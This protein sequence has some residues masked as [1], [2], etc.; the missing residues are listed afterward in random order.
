M[1][2]G[3][4]C[5]LPRSYFGRASTVPSTVERLQLWQQFLDNRP[6]Q[7]SD[8]EITELANK[9]RLSGEQIQQAIAT[10]YNLA[11]WS[12]PDNPQISLADC[13]QACRK[14]SNQQ[15]KTLARKIKPHYQWNDLVLPTEPLQQLQEICGYVKHRAIVYDRWGFDRKLAL[16]KGLSIL[17]SGSSGT[18]KTMAADI[19]AG[20]LGLELYKID[21]SAVVSKY[22]GETEK[23]LA[24]I[25]NEAETSNAILFFDEADALFGK[26]SEVKDA[27]DRYANIETSYLLQRMEE[28]AG[29]VIL[30]TNFRKNMDD[31][32]V[33]R[34]HFNDSSWVGVPFRFKPTRVSTATT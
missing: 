11:L 18:G 27:R 26:R 16:G 22:I 13:Y 10:A 24:Q 7:L 20:E 1:N 19:M 4:L 32:F 8:T 21:L 12:N 34:L 3:L 30:A 15:L 25:F 6:I 17:F 33:R 2:Y 29:I 31:A 28:Y 5:H 23:N 9:F 14:Q